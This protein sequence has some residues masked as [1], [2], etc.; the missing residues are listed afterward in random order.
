MK[1]DLSILFATIF[2]QMF[3]NL[4]SYEQWCMTGTRCVAGG[5]ARVRLQAARAVVPE[6]LHQQ[7]FSSVRPRLRPLPQHHLADRS[8]AGVCAQQYDTGTDVA[9][10]HI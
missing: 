7:G 6:R 10:Q 4:C 5:S 3:F 1:L 2:L 8:G 9:N